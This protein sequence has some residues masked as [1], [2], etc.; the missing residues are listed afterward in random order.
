MTVDTGRFEA[1]WPE[2]SRILDRLLE[3]P[4]DR[5]AEFIEREIGDDVELR[6]IVERLLDADQRGSQFLG[7]SAKRLASS[8]L[9]HTPEAIVNRLGRFEI[10]KTLGSGGMG[11]VFEA[12]DRRLQRLVAI[13]VLAAA[14]VLD[15]KGR[16]R[17]LR[18]ARAASSVDHPNICTV[19]DIGEVGGHLYIV[20]SRYHGE[21]LE[22]CLQK[23]PMALRE[24]LEI[25][26]QVTRG[27]AYAHRSG[28]VHRDIKP[29]NILL[30]A[31]G[32]VKILD[33]GIAKVLGAS[34]LTRTDANPGTL[35]YMA[36]ELIEGQDADARSDLWSVGVVLYQM[37][38]GRLPFGRRGVV[39]ATVN[40]ILNTSLPPLADSKVPRAVERLL[41]RALEKKPRD[42]FQDAETFLA[43][44][45]AVDGVEAA[46]HSTPRKIE[47][48]SRTV[49]AAGRG[50]SKTTLGVVGLLLALAVLLIFAKRGLIG[51]GSVRVGESRTVL[52]E[53]FEDRNTESDLAWLG[54]A[55]ASMLSCDLAQVDSLVVPSGCG[56]SARLGVPV[57]ERSLGPPDD[58]SGGSHRVKGWYLAIGGRLRLDVSV[59]QPSGVRLDSKVLQR[60]QEEILDLVA[61]ASSF[62]RSTLGV[63]AGDTPWLAVEAMSTGSF[64]AWR[65]YQTAL[66]RYREGQRSAAIQE[67]ERALEADPEFALALADLGLLYANAG[68][69]ARARKYLERARQQG[70]RLPSA[71]RDQVLA[72]ILAS[73]WEGAAAAADIL[74]RQIAQNRNNKGVRNTLAAIYGGWEDY[75]RAAALYESLMAAGTQHPGSWEAAVSVAVA[76]G[77]FD[78]AH[79]ILDE[80]PAGVASDWRLRWKRGWV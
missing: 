26:R 80:L 65:H 30:T 52:V 59:M 10:L 73:T 64:D 47:V 37:L 41:K 7:A 45:D 24:A 20:M 5:R 32:E 69:L 71:Q 61:D 16:K 42:R 55:V 72:E 60:D 14:H 63:P 36:P 8:L 17:F 33:F 3:I 53:E 29:A 74:E 23:R 38:S 68:D 31:S 4:T 15:E 40:A 50:I 13:K 54:P 70:H 6:R 79:R 9:E 77:D 67:L 43:A 78:R 18:E 58:V 46:M 35:A 44:L 21:T 2:V 51:R 48:M 76:R 25:V 56:F 34:R 75:E 57:A 19:H 62:V 28:I 11:Q 27:L 49:V 12:K 22:A 39:G 1:R 66:E